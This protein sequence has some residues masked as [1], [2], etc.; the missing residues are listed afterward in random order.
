MSKTLVVLAGPTASGKTRTGIE[1]AK[2]FGTEIISADSRQ[3]YKE[4]RIGTAVPSPG[5]LNTVK[6]HFIREISLNDYYN[7]SMYERDVNDVDRKSTRLNS[8]HRSL[9]RMPS[10]A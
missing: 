1:L 8:S 4:T 10:S 6:H 3:I 7:A 9:S 2:F 5:E